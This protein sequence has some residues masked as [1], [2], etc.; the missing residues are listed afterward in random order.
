LVLPHAPEAQWCFASLRTDSVSQMSKTN[1]DFS[2]LDTAPLI[3]DAIYSGGTFRNK[4]GGSPFSNDPLSKL[5]RV[6]NEGGIRAKKKVKGRWP[7]VV[8]KSTRAE[9]DWPDSFDP[10]TG[11]FKY[12]GDNRT[13]GQALL[14]RQGNR[15]LDE[16]FV[17]LH[18]ERRDL[19]PPFF[20]FVSTGSGHDVRLLGTAAPGFPGL[21]PS[22][23]LIPKWFFSSNGQRFQNLE[24]HFTMMDVPVSRE[25]LRDL[26]EGRPLSDKCPG[27]WRE[28]VKTGKYRPLIAEPIRTVRSKS[29]QLPPPSGEDMGMLREIHGHFSSDAFKFERFSGDLFRW[30]RPD[31]AGQIDYT[32]P[33]KDGGRDA[34]GKV[35][36][37][38]GEP[39][40]IGEFALEA[41][42]Y[43]PEHGCGVHE[44]SRL[45]GRLR[46]RMFGVFV[47]TSYLN[48]QAY[49]EVRLEDRHPIVVL[50]GK[51]IV[52]IMRRL[53]YTNATQIRSL[54]REQYPV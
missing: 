31:L 11:H 26:A 34:V 46:Y 43:A 50:C 19:I 44:I 21:G 29:S 53:G 51:D 18:S 15:L 45:S 32:R 54:L 52:E 48:S 42:C 40:V 39:V 9:S 1:F 14:D 7:Y 30:H 2:K 28:W 8:L 38:V 23:Q 33:Y 37:G 35:F 10:S 41:K 5:M 17:H 25:W 49:E 47:T 24:A 4:N 20:V 6:K 3:A 27:A 12:Y 36:A 16:V 22:E 13:V